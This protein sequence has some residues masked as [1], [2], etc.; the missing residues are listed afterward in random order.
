[1]NSAVG[2]ALRDVS[3][4]EKL[5]LVEDLWDY[6]ANPAEGSSGEDAKRGLARR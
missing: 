1:M 5:I 2:P 6:L 4:S 3:F